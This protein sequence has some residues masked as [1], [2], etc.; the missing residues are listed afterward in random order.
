MKRGVVIAFALVL[1]LIAAFA[2]YGQL[3]P[4]AAQQQQATVESAQTSANKAL[5]DYGDV[6]VYDADGSAR[7]LSGL[8][9]GAPAIVNY[10]A[11]WCPNCVE[12]MDDYQ[13]L[14]EKYGSQVRFVM[15]DATDGR[16]ETREKADA[17]IAEHGYSFPVY[18]DAEQSLGMAF[19]LEYLPTTIV[20]DRDGSIVSNTSGRIDYTAVDQLLGKL[21][22]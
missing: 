9:E 7:D 6:R 8:C 1:V 14:F 11:T 21:I 16:R 4:K 17:Y 15:V 18:Y 2:A 19:A 5:A 22:A 10:W 13:K 20:V 12:E 3:S